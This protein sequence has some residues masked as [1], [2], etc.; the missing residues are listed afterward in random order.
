LKAVKDGLAKHNEKH[1]NAA[2]RISK[3]MLQSTPPQPDAG[4][5]TE[6]GYINQNKAQALRSHDVER[7]YSARIDTKVI[8]LS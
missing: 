8:K 5:I 7:L 2:S 1:P 4:E 3:I 6:K